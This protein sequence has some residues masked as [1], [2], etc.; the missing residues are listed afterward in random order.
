[1]TQ[2]QRIRTI[3]SHQ[4]A[5]RCGFWLGQPLEETWKIYLPYFGAATQEEVRCRLGDH[6]RWMTPD[7]GSLYSR[8]AQPLWDLFA[9]RPK[10]SH[11]DPGIFADCDSVQEVADYPWPSP[12]GMDF[13]EP[14]AALRDV[15]DVYRAGGFWTCFYHNVMDL[16]GMENYLVKMYENPAVVHAVTDHVCQWY[17][18]AND[19]YF[20]AAGDEV[21]AF[22]FGNDFGTQ[23]DLILSPA[24][25]DEFVF[26]WFRKFIALAKRHGRQVMAHSC[27][28]IHRVIDRMID[29]G[30]DC[31]HPL[32]ALA[33]NMDA[34]SLAKDFKGR[35][36]FLGGIDTQH[37]L[38]HATPQQVKD[39]VRRV[40]ETL[41]PCLIVSPSHEGILPNVPP[42]NI[43]AMAEA[44]A[45]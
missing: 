6:I 32:Q 45:E 37:L 41:G 24:M 9:N 40:K 28:A 38:V 16:F 5:D 31:L 18:D 17:Y 8:G 25:L 34:D 1:M 30:V 7:C 4:P 33:R 14:L 12:K 19:A 44:A 29:A 11:G 43:V 21:D 22:F 35:L 10:K 20:A 13:T 3:I 42:E 26:P 23:L 36:A 27:G 15:G 2:R 39:D